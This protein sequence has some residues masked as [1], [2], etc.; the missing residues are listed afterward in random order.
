M[1]PPRRAVPFP[2]RVNAG[3]SYFDARKITPHVHGVAVA[4]VQDASLEDDGKTSADFSN[5]P[6]ERNDAKDGK[7]D[8]KNVG[9][10]S[11]KVSPKVAGK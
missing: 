7:A 10:R 8:Q 9:I 3:D 5:E 1:I 11:Q 4:H 2:V 6:P